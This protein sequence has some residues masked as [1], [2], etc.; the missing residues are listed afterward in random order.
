MEYRLTAVKKEWGKKRPCQSIQTPKC[1]MQV[2]GKFS[3]ALKSQSQLQIEVSQAIWVSTAALQIQGI[4]FEEV[5]AV[6]QNLFI[7]HLDNLVTSFI[8]NN[9]PTRLRS[10]R[11][12]DPGGPQPGIV[13]EHG[14]LRNIIINSSFLEI[15]GRWNQYDCIFRLL[16]FCKEAC[17]LLW[18][19]IACLPPLFFPFFNAG[20][21]FFGYWNRSSMPGFF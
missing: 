20:T 13:I 17:N 11:A 2:S 6:S 1:K 18:N 14:R 8:S 12:I 3:T 7:S 16:I 19:S 15:A 10:N 21:F 4:S 5:D 9:H